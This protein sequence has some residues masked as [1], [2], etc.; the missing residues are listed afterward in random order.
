MNKQAAFDEI[1]RIQDEYIDELIRIINT[2]DYANLKAISFTSA[3]GTG[4]T[5][6]MSKLINKFPDYYFIITTLS[7][8]QLHHQVRNSL[9]K[10]CNYRNFTVYGSA[11]YKINSRLDAMGIIKKIPPMTRCIWLRDEGHIKT[12]R[13]D[14][15]LLDK[16]Y[17]VINFSA[18]NQHSDIQC[19]FTQTMMLRTVNQTT[20]TPEEAINKLIEVKELHKNVIHYNPCAI[21][22]CVGGNNSLHDIIVDLCIKHGLKYIDI[23]NE[24]F[25]MSVLCEDDNEYDVII[26]KFKLIEGIDIRRAHVL[27]MDNQPN[28]NATTI[29][30]IGR[31]RRNALLYRDDI[32]ILAP[33]NE[34]LLKGTRECYVYYNVEKMKISTDE[35]GELQ[36]AFCNYVSCEELKPNTT[37]DVVNGQLPNGLYIIELDGKTG[38]FDI[39]IDENTG[40][41]TV[42]PTTDFYDNVVT[43]T[44]NYIYTYGMK[45]TTDNVLKLP[46]CV[47][48]ILSYSNLDEN[49]KSRYKPYY[50][51]QNHQTKNNVKCNVS[52]THKIIFSKL[53][54]KYTEKYL[55][56]K[57]SK[58]CFDA[59]MNK[60]KI[61]KYDNVNLKEYIETFLEE[62]KNKYGLKDFC[63]FIS[64]IGNRSTGV[65]VEDEYKNFCLHDFCDQN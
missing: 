39:T 17:K 23:S 31:C 52:D 49:I 12:N 22:R 62:N 6:M 3:T 25:T 65:E 30:A 58:C 14:E 7:K 55:H 46:L 41:N 40:F 9:M 59:I 24:P 61:T 43:K 63:R 56:T 16:C 33:E 34:E 45:I 48:T 51:L 60:T 10:D 42:V 38:R 28:N 1:N 57:L 26:N 13:F 19:N 47:P 53:R 8:G 44:N 36:M 29:Q 18:T 37:I 20:G 50:I 11:D 5:K 4:K 15:L 2:P 54:A 21:F 32:D 64:N 35:N 27:Y